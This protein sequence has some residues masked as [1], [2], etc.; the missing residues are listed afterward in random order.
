MGPPFGVY[1]PELPNGYIIT[2]L[3]IQPFFSYAILSYQGTTT[4]STVVQC[5]EFWYR[6]VR[7]NC[8][9]TERPLTP[10][11]VYPKYLPTGKSGKQRKR[12]HLST[13]GCTAKIILILNGDQNQMT[14]NM[15]G[16]QHHVHWILSSGPNSM[17]C[18][19]YFLPQ[20]FHV[21]C[22]TFKQ[23]LELSVA[24]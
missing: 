4:L 24:L 18:C 2:S 11:L 6:I 3:K 13:S 12:R 10:N 8:P 21:K 23:E 19:M 22:I 16:L 15:C 1:S 20:L 7:F 17:E 9:H 5:S 14:T